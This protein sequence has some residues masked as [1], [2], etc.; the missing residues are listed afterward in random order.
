MHCLNNEIIQFKDKFYIQKRGIITGGNDSVSIANISLHYIIR[1]IP[2]INTHTEFFTRYIDD[3]MY[4]TLDDENKNIIQEKL[5][6]NFEEE[7]LELTF[8]IVSTKEEDQKLEFLDVLHCTNKSQTKGF[9]IKNFI[10]P[11]AENATFINGKSFHPSHVYKGIIIGEAKRMER[12]NENK[13]DYEKS[14]EQ[15]E[16]KCKKSGFNNKIITKTIDEIKQRRK[17]NEENNLTYQNITKVNSNEKNTNKLTWTTRFKNLLRFTKREKE[18][19]P[20]TQIVYTRPSTIRSQL[21]NYKNIAIEEE[22]QQGKSRPCG[23]CAVCGSHGKYKK[24]HNMVEETKFFKT[25]NGKKINI[26]QNLDC[27]DYGIYAAKCVQCN[28]LYIGQTVTSFSKRWTQ[29]RRKWNNSVVNY[30]SNKQQEET[31]KYNP[32]ENALFKHFVKDHLEIIS[33]DLEINQAYNVI[34]IDQPKNKKDLDTLESFYI[35]ITDSKINIAKTCL[36]KIR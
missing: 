17:K 4:I 23:K 6:E 22:A 29:H 11:T 9:T 30:S 32:D 14:I 3:I 2:Q 33:Q 31:N 28:E 13:E 34:F 26:N 36:P 10:K 8:R 35:G 19:L 25:T 18:L 20:R 1:K 16:N 12:L 7:G 15:L 21:I 5:R 27:S 24:K